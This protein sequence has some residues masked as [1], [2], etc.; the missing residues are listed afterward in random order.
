MVG[1]YRIK[2]TL[3]REPK[4]LANLKKEATMHAGGGVLGHFSLRKKVKSVKKLTSRNE[5]LKVGF[6][7]RGKLGGLQFWALIGSHNSKNSVK[8][9]IWRRGG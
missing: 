1:E 9:G 2:K 5:D 6:L 4:N 7:L 3:L 8:K